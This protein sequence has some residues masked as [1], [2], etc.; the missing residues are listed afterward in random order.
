M[1]ACKSYMW[2]GARQEGGG[3]ARAAR[4]FLCV[5]SKCV[6][7]RV[8]LCGCAWLASAWELCLYLCV[9]VSFEVA[10]AVRQYHLHSNH[11]RQA[12]DCP[13]PQN[14]IRAPA[15]PA[16]LRLYSSSI[17]RGTQKKRAWNTWEH[18]TKIASS[19]DLPLRAPRKAA[20]K[21]RR[22]GR[23]GSSISRPVLFQRKSPPSPL[24][25]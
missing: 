13:Y 4:G 16:I 11:H 6:L 18:M 23:E 7:R 20:P 9:F 15:T 17:S 8:W 3:L 2:C 24:A 22:G 25:I 5:V 19:G 21:G 14:A 1:R 10:K 12:V